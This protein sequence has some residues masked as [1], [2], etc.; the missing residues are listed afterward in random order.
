MQRYAASEYS[1][2]FGWAVEKIGFPDR[3]SIDKIVES[4]P[5][6]HTI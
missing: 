3:D 5:A 4:A 2:R 6:R 1:S